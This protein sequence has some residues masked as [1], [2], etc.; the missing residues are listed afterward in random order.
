[1]KQILHCK[2]IVSVVVAKMPINPE[3]DQI[4]G[5]LRY[6]VCEGISDQLLD[7]INNFRRFDE[8]TD[9]SVGQQARR[10]WASEWVKRERPCEGPRECEW[11]TDRQMPSVRVESVSEGDSKGWSIH[12]PD[13]TQLPSKTPTWPTGRLALRNLPSTFYLINSRFFSLFSIN[14]TSVDKLIVICRLRML[15]RLIRYSKQFVRV[16]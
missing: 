4:K 10:G 9:K 13:N 8:H 12:T 6:V 16:I 15:T 3:R 11:E 1:M 5:G 2:R 14:V 7:R